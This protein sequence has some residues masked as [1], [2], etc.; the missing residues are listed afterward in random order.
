MNGNDPYIMTHSGQRLYYAYP[1]R[2]EYSLKDIGH[3]LSNLCR[4]AGQGGWFSV[5]QHC[6][7]VAELLEP[8]D[9]L[10]GLLH[11]A[12]EAFMVDV[13]GPLKHMDFMSGYRE[14]EERVTLAIN[15]QF[16]LSPDG[17][18]DLRVKSVD[19]AVR[20][21]EA[22]YIGLTR[23]AMWDVPLNDLEMPQWLSSMSNEE[24]CK[25]FEAKGLWLLEQ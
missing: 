25:A 15:E 9:K 19:V 2:F 7:Y 11:D 5:A 12:S 22:N 6:L 3:A 1:E 8:R 23:E 24:A 16:G 4:Y 13:P 18:A 17:E 21:P 14:L 10:R 20:W